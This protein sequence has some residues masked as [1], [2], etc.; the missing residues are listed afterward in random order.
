M[1]IFFLSCL[2]CIKIEN[3]G[4]KDKEMKANVNMGGLSR[5]FAI[6]FCLLTSHFFA[7][8]CLKFDSIDE[9]LTGWKKMS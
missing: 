8:E 5:S 4:M 3:Y 6:L 1:K 7:N 2:E 9:F